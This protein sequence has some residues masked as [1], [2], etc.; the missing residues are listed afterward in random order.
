MPVAAADGN[1]RSG[2]FMHRHK[3][4]CGVIWEHPEGDLREHLCPECGSPHFSR[5]YGDRP[6]KY[7]HP[8]PIFIGPIEWFYFADEADE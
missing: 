3:C 8:A 2:L 5:Y 6:T 4:E 7:P 1:D